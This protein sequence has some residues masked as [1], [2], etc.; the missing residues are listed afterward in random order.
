MNQGNLGNKA[1]PYSIPIQL[2]GGPSAAAP[3]G[4]SSAVSTRRW[5][6]P[7]RHGEPIPG[8]K[9]GIEVFTGLWLRTVNPCCL[10]LLP[11]PVIVMARMIPFLAGDSYKPSWLPLLLGRGTTQLVVTLS[12]VHAKSQSFCCFYQSNPKMHDESFGKA[13][14]N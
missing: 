5:R 8:G 11:F 1:I 9:P 2:F 10:G 4:R 13:L 14:G 12:F 7:A 6:L 3:A